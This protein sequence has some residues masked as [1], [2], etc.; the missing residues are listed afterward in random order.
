[1]KCNQLIS[2]AAV[3]MFLAMTPQSSLAARH[4]EITSCPY[5]ANVAGAIYTI[6]QKMDGHGTCIDVTAPN[7]TLKMNGQGVS[8][9]IGVSIEASAKNA[10]ILGP[11][12]VWGGIVDQGDSALIRD[13][14]LQGDI[15]YGLLI[16]GA[17]GVI[18]EHNSIYGAM[19]VD[20]SA[21]QKCKIDRNRI[22][23]T[24]GG[25]YDPAYAI[26]IEPAVSKGQSKGNIISNNN[27]K[28]S[29]AGGL[30]SIG[31]L[32]G[33]P[34][35]ET[36]NCQP[37]GRFPIEGTLIVNNTSTEHSGWDTPGVGIALGCKNDSAHS[38]VKGN[39]ALNNQNYDLY[40]GN[41][42][43]GTNVWSGN[44]FKTSNQSCIK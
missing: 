39:T 43:C 27:L 40:D 29:G 11:G 5:T 44:H 20:L 3:A 34:P 25:R 26:S 38:V 16:W 13:L 17:S 36:G 9:G 41:T 24:S 35:D 7:I 32:V 2:A 1:M 10:H 21:S 28:G 19:G 31:I 8:G 30:T 23:A 14:V 33:N 4:I 22:V 37:T 12:V 42:N 6:A 18:V 15:G